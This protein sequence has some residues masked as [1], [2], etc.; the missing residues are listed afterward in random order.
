MVQNKLRNV[1]GCTAANPCGKCEGD[2]NDDNDCR[3]DLK[4][5]QRDSCVQIPG[6]YDGSPC[7]YDFCHDPND[8]LTEQDI[9]S[10]ISITFTSPTDIGEIR[11][12]EKSRGRE[13]TNF[14]VD[15]RDSN[16]GGK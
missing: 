7:D 16:D 9:T 3:G 14:K 8:A 5:F 4:C 12:R 11:I 2:C 15:I 13:L 1:G 10:A 6:C